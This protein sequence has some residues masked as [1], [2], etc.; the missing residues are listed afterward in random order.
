MDLKAFE[1]HKFA[2][3]AAGIKI[4]FNPTDDG[5]VPT[6]TLFQGGQELEAKRVE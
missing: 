2:N 6:F 3:E 1:T 4:R 5:K